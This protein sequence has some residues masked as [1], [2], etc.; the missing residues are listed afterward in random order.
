MA[1]SKKKLVVKRKRETVREKAVK[2]SAKKDKT[3]RIRKLADTASKTKGKVSGILSK[4]YTPFKTGD[5]KAGQFLGKSRRFTPMYFVESFRELKNVTW[6]DK[7]T[8]AKLTL[9]VFI[10]SFV[11]AAIVK[12]LD[13]GFEKLF[14][15]VILK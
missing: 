11:L 2:S 1:E 5:S 9:A 8:T 6:P 3:P 4:E 13:F 7:K 10:F 15:D 14:R 12:G